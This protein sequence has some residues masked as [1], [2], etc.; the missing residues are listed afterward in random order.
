MIS[1]CFP[2]GGEIL[3]LRPV[4]DRIQ[5]STLNIHVTMLINP[6]QTRYNSY[7][8]IINIKHNIY[9]RIF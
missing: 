7:S 5:F 2:I 4:A 6:T 1:T 9:D 8:D 3:T